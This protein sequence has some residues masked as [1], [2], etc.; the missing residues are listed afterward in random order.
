MGFCHF[1]LFRYVSKRF[2]SPLSL[3][4]YF[5][6]MEA[7]L[8]LALPIGWQSLSDSQ[9]LYFFRRFSRNLPMEEILTLCLFK[10]AD[11]RVL[12]C[13]PPKKKWLIPRHAPPCSQAT[14]PPSVLQIQTATC[15]IDY[16][17]YFP[18][19]SVRITAIGKAHAIDRDFLEVPLGQLYNCFSTSF[20]LNDFSL[21][22][23]AFQLFCCTFA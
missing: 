10:W 14:G 17:H 1:D 6:R 4:P 19:M 3:P 9:L 20:I 23:T 22:I 13:T 5:R 15:A 16:L 21:K 7:F 12:C 2:V 18:I 11:L 8:K